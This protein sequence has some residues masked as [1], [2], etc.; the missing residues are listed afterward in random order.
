MVDF[1]KKLKQLRTQSGLSQKQL[2]DQIGVTKSVVS[3]Y[4]LQ[5][6]YP[7]PDVLIKLAGIFH[8]TSDY[9]L[10][11]ETRRM[12]DVSDLNND[13]IS[14]LQHVLD[15]LRRNKNHTKKES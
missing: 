2:A 12:L 3:Y 10:G 11:I 6:R 13:E 4:E 15:V 14:M 9:L 8:V 1:G 7:S 5:E